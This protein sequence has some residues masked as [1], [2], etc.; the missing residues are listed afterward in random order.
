MAKTHKEQ[1][2]DCAI[3]IIA[4]H[5][6]GI[7]YKDLRAA[8]AQELPNMPANTI[9]GTIWNLEV[10][11]PAYVSKP[12]RGVYL[13]T[14]YSA[15]GAGAAMA[16][17]SVSPA[18]VKE[19]A[20]YEPFAEYLVEELEECTKAVAVGGALFKDKWGTPDVV[21]VRVPRKS[22]IVQVPTEIISAEIKLE[23]AGLIT[24]FGQ[25]CAY[26]LFSHRSY[27][28]VPKTAPVDD[29]ARLDSLCQ[30]FGVG[31]ILFNLANPKAPDFEIRVR[32]TRHEPDM[33]Y[34]NQ[35]MRLLEDELFS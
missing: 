32:A 24:A 7:R 14:K 21:G 16:T 28:V 11:V 3:A 31:L 15:A 9:G 27:I 22:D 34:V 1:V 25:A 2:Q 19:E 4:K 18:K 10:T 17:T 23:P 30:I 35:N 33:F 29:I 26:K 6:E 5:P 12:S 20:F 13:H 8:I